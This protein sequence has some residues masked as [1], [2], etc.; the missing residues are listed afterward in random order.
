MSFKTPLSA[1]ERLARM[2]ENAALFNVPRLR[3]SFGERGPLA[4]CGFGPSLADT[5]QDIEGE[6]MTTSGA[7]DFLISR[8]IVPKYHVELD[9]REHKVNFIR[10]SH[11][12]VTYLINSQCHRTMFETL[13]AAGRTVWMWHG[14][15]DDGANE[16]I[17][18]LEA[19]EPGTR[20]M[21]G[22]T[23]AGMRSIIVARE[24][25]YTRFE[26][27]GMDC[28]YRGTEQWAG[29]HFT[30]KQHAV[31]VEVEGRI[32]ETSD[33]MLQSTDDFFNQLRILENCSFRIHGDGLLEARM[34]MF[35][36]DR[37]KA[38][39]VGWWKPVGFKIEHRWPDFAPA[40]SL[41]AA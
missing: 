2:R 7:H 13:L 19:L 9:A 21:A 10:N 31:R 24:L 15:T 18:M 5:W 25:N 32:F 33:L 30:K 3:Q 20:L 35:M 38:L 8:G 36:R 34:R 1:P 11:P 37:E 26:L 41:K 17:K 12:G 14:F 28:C 29:E 22:G 27:H 39:N 6:A 4:V 16:Q 40:W 23:N